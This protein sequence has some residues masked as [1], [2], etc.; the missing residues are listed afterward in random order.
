MDS[1]S[2]NSNNHG[3]KL[4]EIISMLC[5]LISSC[6]HSLNNTITTMYIEFILYIYC[7]KYKLELKC[8][9]G[10]DYFTYIHRHYILKPENL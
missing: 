5:I 7:M 4:L 8:M 10:Y 9:E 6:Y 2:V 1:G 3:S